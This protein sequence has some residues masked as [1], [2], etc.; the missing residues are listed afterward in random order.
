MTDNTY[1]GWTNWHTFSVGTLILNDEAL[2][3]SARRYERG[4]AFPSWHSFIDCRGLEDLVTCDG[5]AF[6]DPKL[7]T[8]ELD[9]II[10]E[11]NS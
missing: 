11:I 4:T 1:N 10:R 3:N 6:S 9:E 7:D 5:V 2:Y 8:A